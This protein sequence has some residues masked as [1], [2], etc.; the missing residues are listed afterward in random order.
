MRLY[1]SNPPSW[2]P[3]WVVKPR[4]AAP[5]HR[6]ESIILDNG[7]FNYYQRGEYPSLDL[8]VAHLARRASQ[9]RWRA[10]ELY[11]VL[12]DYPNEPWR[13]IMAARRARH[14][15][16]AYKCI[17][18]MHYNETDSAIL[19][20]VF[21]TYMSDIDFA[22]L[23][24]VPL[25][26]PTSYHYSA[27][28]RRVLVKPLLQL[29]IINVADHVA[30]RHHVD[31]HLLAPSL[32]A[33]KRVAAF[34]RVKSMDTTSWT[35]A[36]PELKK[37]LGTISAKNTEQRDLLFKHYLNILCRYLGKLEGWKCDNPA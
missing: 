35:R 25:K 32:E 37:K 21:D 29:R 23:Y 15:C 6:V 3:F 17:L 12:P 8:W 4:G 22:E 30:R 20:D 33:A 16:K 28:G 14:L 19:E 11:V 26:L 18:V 36:P 9:L 10:E 5:G 24:A 13:T 7:A 27:K 31:L 2:W 1:A 34:T